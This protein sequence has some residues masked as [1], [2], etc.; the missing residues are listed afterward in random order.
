VLHRDVTIT[1]NLTSSGFELDIP[2]CGGLNNSCSTSVS[3]FCCPLY[4][5]CWWWN[6]CTRQSIQHNKQ[7]IKKCEPLLCQLK[8]HKI[9]MVCLVAVSYADKGRW[10]IDPSVCV[11]VLQCSRGLY[12]HFLS[13]ILRADTPF[14]HNTQ[15]NTPHY[16]I[17]FTQFVSQAAAMLSVAAQLYRL[18]YWG[19]D[20]TLIPA[21]HIF[22]LNHH[23]VNSSGGR[24]EL[25]VSLHMS[26]S[27]FVAFLSF[28][29]PEA[30]T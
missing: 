4:I 1:N 18:D 14:L 22:S 13:Q 11:L 17:C 12:S 21:H 26:I 7:E 30:H 29:D 24:K 20:W 28:R 23:D 25:S 2:A 6:T 10:S 5:N 16:S 19:Q 8:W 27:V 9:H 3:S 15:W